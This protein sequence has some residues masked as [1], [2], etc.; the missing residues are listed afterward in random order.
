MRRT[1]GLVRALAARWLDRGRGGISVAHGLLLI[2]VVVLSLQLLGPHAWFG[3]GVGGLNV[4]LFD[5]TVAAAALVLIFRSGAWA[6]TLAA[7]GLLTLGAYGWLIA[8]FWPLPG[9]AYGFSD[10]HNS[11][12]PTPLWADALEGSV[13]AG[14]GPVAGAAAVMRHH[15]ADP[16]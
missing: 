2:P 3:R 5:L 9:F 7:A 1:R 11:P 8:V 15:L 12:M 10:L 16:A 13:L 14:P 6:A 4:V